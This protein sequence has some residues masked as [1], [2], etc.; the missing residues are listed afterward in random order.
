MPT[1]ICSLSDG[2]VP[3]SFAR[4]ISSKSRGRVESANF[5]LSR[6]LYNDSY[7]IDSS[8]NSSAAVAGLWTVPPMAGI[9][10]FCVVWV[11]ITQRSC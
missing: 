8:S 5:A 9:A 6:D 2:V 7:T 4:F 11:Q 1:A 10:F 3:S